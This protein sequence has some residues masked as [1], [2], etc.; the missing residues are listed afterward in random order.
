MDN[1]SLTARYTQAVNLS[2]SYTKDKNEQIISFLMEL[3]DSGLL[4]E[5]NRDTKWE[6]LIFSLIEKS[7][8]NVKNLLDYRFTKNPESVLFGNCSGEISKDYTYSEV[9][10]N[11]RKIALYLSKI[12]DA[13]PLPKDFKIAILSENC[14]EMPLVDLGALYAG[15]VDVIIPPNLTEEHISFILNQSKPKI[16]FIQST[17]YYDKIKHSDYLKTNEIPLISLVKPIPDTDIPVLKDLILE[18]NSDIDTNSINNPLKIDDLATIMY[19][20]GTTGEPKGIMFSNLNIILKR[21]AR[22]LALPEIGQKDIFLSYLPLFHTFGRYLEMMGAIFWGAQYIFADNSSIDT[23]T[24][25]MRSFKPTIFI[26]I[27]KKWVQLNE[28]ICDRIDI[29]IADQKDILSK[30]RE[31]TGGE[32]KWGLSAAGYLS[33]DVFNF[34]NNYEI[35]LLSGFGMTE[36]TGGVT[37]TP[38]KKYRD[39][40][41]GLP[42]PGI[43]TSLGEESELLIRG[44]YVMMGY[45]G[46]LEQ[47]FINDRWFPTGDI[48]TIDEDGYHFIVDRKK[49]IY[50]NSRGESI[51]PQKIENLF[52]ESEF[53]KQVFLVGDHRPFNTLLI[54][55][56]FDSPI[57]SQNDTRID[58]LFSSLIVSVNKFLPKHER[59]IDYRLIDRPFAVEKE[60]I[61]PKN[62]LKRWVIEKNF[63]EQI[64]GMYVKNYKTLIYN[65]L[66]INIPNW[67]LK[68]K[69]LIQQDI[70]RVDN[71]IR[72]EKLQKNLLLSQHPE[73]SDVIRVGDFYYKTTF[74]K[75]NLEDIFTDPLLWLGNKSLFEFCDTSITEW[76]RVDRIKGTTSFYEVAA[77]YNFSNYDQ[78]KSILT[79]N[80]QNPLLLLHFALCFVYSNENLFNLLG[81]NYLNSFIET[82][83]IYYFKISKE[84]LGRINIISNQSILRELFA[85]VIKYL[86]DREFKYLLELYLRNFY[87]LFDK[88]LTNLFIEYASG[89]EL[90]VLEETLDDLIIKYPVDANIKKSSIPFLLNVLC[91]YGINHPTKYVH[92]RQIF[93]KYETLFI[94]SEFSL[95]ASQNRKQMRVGF[96]NWLGEVTRLAVDP[97]TGNEYKWSDVIIFDE[98]VSAEDRHKIV[99][100]IKES[101]IIREAVFLVTNGILISL[102]N[103][104][105]SGVFISGYR[106]ELDRRIYKINIQTRFQGSFSILLTLYNPNIREKIFEEINWMILAGSRY[107]LT[108]LVEDFGGIWDEHEMWTSKYLPS[109]TVRRQIIRIFKKN[110]NKVASE[111]DIILWHFYIWNCSATYF[112]FIRLTNF[113]HKILS[114]DIDA[115][116]VPEHDYNLGSRLVTFSTR[117]NYISFKESIEIFEKCFINK[118][119]SEYPSL[120]NHNYP[121]FIYSGILNAFGEDLGLHMLREYLLIQKNSHLKN[122]AKVELLTLF[123]Y[124][125]EKVGFLPKQVYFAINRFLRWY[126]INHNASNSALAHTLNDIYETYQLNAFESEYPELR[127]RFYLQTVFNNSSVKLRDHITKLIN[128]V[129]LKK[130]KLDNISDSLLHIK[131][132]TELSEK[133]EYFLTRL[134]YP[135]VKPDVPAVLVKSSSEAGTETNLVVQYEDC[136]GN[137]LFIRK[138]VNPKEISKLFQ[139]FLDANLRVTFKTE[140]HYLVVTSEQGHIVGGLFFLIEDSETVRMEKIVISRKFR[141]KSISDLLMNDFFSRLVSSNYKN[142][143]TGYYRPEYFYKFGFKLDSKFGGLVKELT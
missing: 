41:I 35:N 120:A 134:T 125:V 52:L 128:N 30:V 122:P 8:F 130:Q 108:E 43:E 50:K 20:S 113:R 91:Q 116:Y 67:F 118:T 86:K 19:T 56:N 47:P 83:N 94:K 72:I 69:G 22:A 101:N 124:E 89:N 11:V 29:E 111:K 45:Y 32:L 38:P 58:D 46:M 28:Y 21:F 40:S 104:V 27:P 66:E 73:Y 44:K 109:D 142:L 119:V 16:L 141:G 60:E 74:N 138:P 17:K 90:S 98:T 1:N 64:Q 39:N 24:K 49:D 33:S 92:I 95:L 105:P 132:D 117:E 2:K 18:T 93:S 12:R 97:D 100:S 31:I 62:T 75:L 23:L 79:D 78:G 102:N 139:L 76:I 54:Y 84:I 85:L 115:F 129:R 13:Y 136:E 80:S 37:M 51:A 135:F 112:N 26:S 14:L 99:D 140:H 88:T 59:I 110:G 127:I 77:L 42:L 55:P 53:V 82:N 6:Q 3:L 71:F 103:I 7:N 106:T 133:E 61:T 96:R 131:L 36:A 9:I 126:D 15:V 87:N 70:T 81:I 57:L 123:I 34:F 143:T 65:H 10:Q 25:L 5:I 137:N 68:E 63:K 121:N 4:K 48:L 107:F 114:P